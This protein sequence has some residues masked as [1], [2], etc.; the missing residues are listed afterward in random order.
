MSSTHNHWRSRIGNALVLALL[1]GLAA[2]LWTLQTSHWPTLAPQMD[3]RLAAGLS[4][5]LW[6]VLCAVTLLLPHKKPAIK[7]QHTDDNTWHVIHASQTGFALELAERSVRLLRDAGQ[8]AQL[9][10]LG[11]LTPQQLQGK[12]CLFIAS[13]TGEGDPPDT[14]LAFAKHID[15]KHQPRIDFSTTQFAVLALGDSSYTEFCAFGH[16]LSRWLLEHGGTPLF[17]LIEVDNAA[18]GA[19]QRWQQQLA[20]LAGQTDTSVWEA[21][22]TQPWILAKRTL[23]NPGSQGWPAYHLVLKPFGSE[24][25]QWQAGDIAEIHPTPQLQRDYSIASISSDGQIELLVRQMQRSDGSP[26]LGS[27]WLCE[28]LNLGDTVPLRI[29]NNPNFHAPSPNTPLILIGNG[30]GIAALRALI[31]ARAQ[32]GAKQTWLI[33]GERSASHDAFFGHEL[34]HWLKNGQLSHLNRTFSRDGHVQRYVQDALHAQSQRLQEWVN[35]GASLYICGSQEGMAPDVE[36]ALND[37]LGETT[38]TTLR[39]T[40]RYRRDV[41]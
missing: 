24:K 41:Y 40:G 23:L 18:P 10:D 5:T 32:E 34:E 21:A 3:V 7:Q 2:W 17:D 35:N 19:L 37:L 33:F 25:P 14:V 20:N 12:R 30:T 28:Q 39:Q 4:F 26:G 22:Q 9:H 16:R 29:R 1:A 36:T 6:L 8:T 27:S 11:E 38:V 15:A 13:T 31:K